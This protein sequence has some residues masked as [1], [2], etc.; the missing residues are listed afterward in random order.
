MIN[1]SESNKKLT[2]KSEPIFEIHKNC[3]IK[4]IINVSVPYKIICDLT[5]ISPDKHSIIIQTLMSI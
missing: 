5:D 3:V 2:V 4:G 1:I